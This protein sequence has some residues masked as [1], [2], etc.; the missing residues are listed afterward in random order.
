[1][2]ADEEPTTGEFPPNRLCPHGMARS[3]AGKDHPEPCAPVIQVRIPRERQMSYE[4]E[5][6]PIEFDGYREQVEKMFRLGAIFGWKPN[7]HKADLIN[8][9]VNVLEHQEHRGTIGW[10]YKER[11]HDLIGLAKAIQKS[12]P[13]VPDDGDYAAGESVF[14]YFSG[15]GKGVLEAWLP[16]LLS[17]RLAS[18]VKPE[19]IKQE[20]SDS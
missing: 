11:E 17:G 16:F 2:H 10:L 3:S 9:L 6:V 15:P 5:E 8:F 12:F 7:F 20:R 18:E 13:D 14:M 19:P 1:M 4:E